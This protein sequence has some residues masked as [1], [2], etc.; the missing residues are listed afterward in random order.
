MKPWKQIAGLYAELRRFD[1]TPII[2]L[3]EAVAVSMADG[4]QA[5][6]EKLILLTDGLQDFAPFHLGL[7]DMYRRL[8]R[9]DEARQAYLRAL[10]LTQNDVE[11]A[12]I[13]DQIKTL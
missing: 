1:D 4:P 9:S 8:A 13:S 11:Q 5:G 3:N 12:F 2:Q 6:L 10:D 7:A